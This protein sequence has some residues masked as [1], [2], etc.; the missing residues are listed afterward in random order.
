MPSSVKIIGE[1][2]SIAAMFV[3]DGDIW[4]S[5][6]GF[7][8]DTD[9][10]KTVSSLSF[11]DDYSSGNI[12]LLDAYYVSGG[13]YPY[14]SQVYRDISN[15]WAV[16]YSNP[17]TASNF[18]W[19]NFVPNIDLSGKTLSFDYYTN[20]GGLGVNISTYAAS[21]GPA[22]SEDWLLS[23]GAWATYSQPIILGAFSL[24]FIMGTGDNTTTSIY[25]D[26]FSIT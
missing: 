24:G 9:V 25:I 3:K 11:F 20:T 4:K 17:I 19:L 5:A 23:D 12:G 18:T 7:I 1:Y 10:W 22:L 14:Y 13:T 26:N 15:N 16:L 2:K 6:N 8:K 21:G